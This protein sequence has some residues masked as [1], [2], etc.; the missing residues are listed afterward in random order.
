[1]DI[2]VEAFMIGKDEKVLEGEPEFEQ[3]STV[4]AFTSQGSQGPGIVMDLYSSSPVVKRTCDETDPYL[5][6]NR[7]KSQIRFY[8]TD[9]NVKHRLVY[10]LN[11]SE[12]I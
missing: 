9:S 12:T 5:L 1:M 6:E 10:S 2:K 7:G 8:S 3:F 11:S 4:Y